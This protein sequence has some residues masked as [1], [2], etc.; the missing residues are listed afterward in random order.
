MPDEELSKFQDLVT[1]QDIPIVESQRPELLPL[2]L[3]AE[4]HVRS[5]RRAIA[6]RRW[7]KQRGLRYGIA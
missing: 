1:G 3:Q 5:D 2:D 7:L 6:Y 4:L